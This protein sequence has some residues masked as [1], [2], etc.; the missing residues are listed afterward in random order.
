MEAIGFFNNKHYIMRPFSYIVI[1]SRHD[2]VYRSSGY[3]F[4]Q[5]RFQQSYKARQNSSILPRPTSHLLNKIYKQVYKQS[6]YR[7]HK[8]IPPHFILE[9]ILD[10]IEKTSHIS[11]SFFIL[12]TK[13]IRLETILMQI[14]ILD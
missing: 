12:H 2:I 4:S 9:Y 6:L 11:D 10:Y 7:G 5:I 8:M 3:S 13:S 1:S 14:S